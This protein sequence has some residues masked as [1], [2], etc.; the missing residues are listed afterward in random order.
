V[1]LDEA[2]VSHVGAAA[3]GFPCGG[4]VGAHGIGREVVDIAVAAGGEDDGVGAV[5]FELAGEEV[6]DDDTTGLAVDEYDID[7]FVAVVHGDCAA[8][9]LAVE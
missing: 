2:G 7:E 6:A 3:H 4:H 9:D 1:Y 8:G 5:A